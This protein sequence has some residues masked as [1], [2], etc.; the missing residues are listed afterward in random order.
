MSAE[1]WAKRAEQAGLALLPGTR[2]AFDRSETQAFRL[3]YGALEEGQ[4]A[5]AVTIL[6]RSW[7]G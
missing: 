2:F 3:G 1:V 4:I 6:A 5:K 7:P